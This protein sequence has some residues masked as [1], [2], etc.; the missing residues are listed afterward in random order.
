LRP[1]A[2]EFGAAA[3]VL[4]AAPEA[5]GAALRWHCVPPAVAPPPV[6][7]AP[8][9]RAQPDTTRALDSTAAASAKPRLFRTPD[10]FRSG[11]PATR[12]GD[13]GTVAEP[14]D[15]YLIGTA[16]VTESSAPDHAVRARGAAVQTA[17]VGAARVST[18]PAAAFLA[19][20]LAVLPLLVS[21][22]SAAAATCPGAD[23]PPPPAAVEELAPGA[24]TPP[25]LPWPVPPVGGA[26][27]GGCGDVL[28]PGAPPLP[29]EL[30]AAGFVL[31]DLDSGAVLAARAPHARQRPASTLKV[32]T[33]LVAVDT[34]DPD[35]TVAGAPEDLSI[36]GSR[37]GIG[38]GGTYT[39]RQ[40][41]AGLLLNSG[42][43]TAQALARAMGGNA[44]T[45]AAMTQTAR[46]LGAFDTRPATPSGLDGPGMAASA[47][48]LALLFRDAMRKPLFAET[49]A[50]RDIPFPGYGDRPGFVLSNVNPLMFH[51]PGTLGSKTG[52]TDAARHT[53]V[54]AAERDGRR[55]VV[56]VVRTENRPVVNWRQAATLLDWGFALPAGTAP[57]GTL[58][59]A[60]PPPPTVSAGVPGPS[61]K[62][63]DP[64]TTA[65][66]WP[67]LAAGGAA[68]TAAAL[69]AVAARR[70]RGRRQ[71]RVL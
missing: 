20:L 31:A 50:L 22:P 61:G 29:P 34:L 64:T 48:D 62:F 52:F 41:L 69:L 16:P 67:A 33:A 53:I 13:L 60:A 58:V 32:L 35:A 2:S 25:P 38:P 11:R 65:L 12:S 51:Y 30:T 19:L 63:T 14:G 71:R 1:D 37:A 4:A 15:N 49:V 59:D 26:A 46:R 45:V 24:V 5:A 70:R 56:S 68:V 54:G 47:Y 21:P 18:A 36:D 28:P 10:A 3:A 9:S 8:V 44:A 42:N 66:P 55:L 27:L 39:V 23:V 57:V 7:G 40:L 17:T 6:E 43:D